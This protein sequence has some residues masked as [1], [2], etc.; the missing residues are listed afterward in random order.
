MIDVRVHPEDNQTN[1]NSWAREIATGLIDALNVITVSNQAVKSSNIEYRVEDNV[2][3][4]IVSYAFKVIRITDAVPDM[5]KMQ[6]G[7]HIK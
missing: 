7:Q 2:L 6:Y 4:F 1:V 5:H 3:H